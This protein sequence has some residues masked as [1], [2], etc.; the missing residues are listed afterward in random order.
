[1]SCCFLWVSHN[2]SDGKLWTSFTLIQ[3]W[4]NTSL[5]DNHTYSRTLKNPNKFK[6][7]EYDFQ[8]WITIKHMWSVLCTN[9]KQK[10]M[11]QRSQLH[12]KYQT[13]LL[14]KSSLYVTITPDLPETKEKK[15]ETLLLLVSS[16]PTH[17]CSV[18]SI[19]SPEVPW[20]W[21]WNQWKQI[22]QFN[23]LPTI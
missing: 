4:I 7:S 5:W 13:Q 22:W 20:D 6:Q 10:E 12:N 2:L 21:P 11:K 8:I 18:S 19:K 1:M 15:N 9:T 17:F 16:S 3:D 14:R 23:F